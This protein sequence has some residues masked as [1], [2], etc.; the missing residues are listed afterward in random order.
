MAKNKKE[1][2]IFFEVD[3]VH[4][5]LRH[6]GVEYRAYRNGLDMMLGSSNANN[7]MEYV[8]RKEQERNDIKASGDSVRT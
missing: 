5:E 1:K 7:L 8:K 3:G 2:S 6:T 4:F